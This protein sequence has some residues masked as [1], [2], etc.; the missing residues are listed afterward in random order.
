M[1]MAPQKPYYGQTKGTCDS[2]IKTNVE[3]DCKFQQLREIHKLPQ[4][5]TVHTGTH[6]FA[7][8]TDI[9]QVEV[10]TRLPPCLMHPNPIR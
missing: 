2:H 10:V 8:V 6:S 9:A 5:P 1:C 4:F 7:I 3:S